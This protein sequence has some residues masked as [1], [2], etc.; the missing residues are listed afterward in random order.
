MFFKT[1]KTEKSKSIYK[2]IFCDENDPNTKFGEWH[3][4][5]ETY[6]QAE[7]RIISKA[8]GWGWAIQYSCNGG[9][10]IDDAWLR[11][12]KIID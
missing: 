3:E 9:Y 8:C 7:H 6:E 5:F 4:N 11:V 2:I 1:K 12:E 10:K